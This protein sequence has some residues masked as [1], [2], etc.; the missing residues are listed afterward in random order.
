MLADACFIWVLIA[1][2]V[3]VVLSWGSTQ[4]PHACR[5]CGAANRRIARYCA[6]CG[7]RLK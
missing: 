7:A 5:R 3:G 4:S 6:R 2:V 1:V